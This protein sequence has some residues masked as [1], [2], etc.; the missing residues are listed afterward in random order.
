[1]TK[2]NDPPIDHARV[3]KLLKYDPVSGYLIWV[4]GARHGAT[5]LTAGSNSND[6]GRRVRIDGHDVSEARLIWFWHYG[7][8]PGA[9]LRRHNRNRR[10]N[11]VENLIDGSSI[12]SVDC[13][14]LGWIT[15]P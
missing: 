7:R 11:R 9:K 2:P 4:Y 6:G 1:M 10:D 15:S 13:A 12:R 14:L 5:G 8:W 3:R